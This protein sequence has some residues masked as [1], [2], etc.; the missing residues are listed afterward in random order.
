MPGSI[1]PSASVFAV[2]VSMEMKYGVDGFSLMGVYI[3]VG[4]RAEWEQNR[5]EQHT[6]R[7]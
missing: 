5:Q 6:I 2:S 1:I 4:E 3:R 7:G